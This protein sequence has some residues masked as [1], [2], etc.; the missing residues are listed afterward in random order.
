[1]AQ[2]RSR[3]LIEHLGFKDPDLTSPAHDSMILWI[4][5]HVREYVEKDHDPWR[6]LAQ[7]V[8][9]AEEA[10]QAEWKKRKESL[11]LDQEYYERDRKPQKKYVYRRDQNG[12]ILDYQPSERMETREEAEKRAEGRK[13]QVEEAQAKCLET[14]QLVGRPIPRLAVPPVEI[15]TEFEKTITTGRDFIVGFVDVVAEVDYPSVYASDID[16]SDTRDTK[17]IGYL[18]PPELRFSKRKEF[19]YFEAKPKIPSFGELLRQIRTYQE[20]TPQCEEYSRERRK[21]HFVIVSP[22]VKF[23]EAIESQK[24]EFWESPAF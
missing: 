1:M 7:Q 12:Q 11:E 15:K 5:E 13:K 14:E 2:Q 4:Q 10:I 6:G 20:Y 24:I 19:F 3:T 9:E 18:R 23:R 16:W 22:D 8:K 21:N 17:I